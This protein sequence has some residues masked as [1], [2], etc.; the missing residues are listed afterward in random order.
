M[1][2]SSTMAA[3][4]ARVVRNGNCCGCGGC[5]LLA[6]ELSM[7]YSQEGFLRPVIPQSGLRVDGRRQAKDFR[8]ICPGVGVKHDPIPDASSH[9][10]FGEYISSWQGWATDDEIRFRGSSGGVITAL[11]S[12]M[13]ETEQTKAVSAVGQSAAKRTTSV[14]LTLTTRDEVLAAAGSRYAPVAAAV[15]GGSDCVSVGKPCEISALQRYRDLQG[16]SAS[17]RSLSISFFCAGTPSQSATDGLVIGMGTELADV[18]GVRYRGQGWPGEFVVTGIDG[19]A[20]GMSYKESWGGHLGKQLQWRC[21]ICVDGTGQESDIAVG[22]YWEADES[23]FPSF[24]SG[25]GRSVIICRTER[26]H[27]TVR[28]AVDAGV[29][30]VQPVSLESVSAIQPLQTDRRFTTLGRLLG[31]IMSGHSVPFYFGFRI[32]SLFGKNPYINAR[33]LVGTYLRSRRGP[34]SARKFD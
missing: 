4:I 7:A 23:G 17:E 29:I 2:R 3:E 28:A 16:E 31:R 21:K 30:V 18:A 22:D 20:K 12:W 24:D 14:A 27:R 8:T 10:V 6:P 26:G 32:V 5:A 25:E 19:T 34:F 33:A 9:P 1:R 11:S 13:L 15:D